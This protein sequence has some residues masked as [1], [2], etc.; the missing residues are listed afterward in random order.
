MNFPGASLDLVVPD[1]PTLD[2]FVSAMFALERGQV[3][4]RWSR[5]DTRGVPSYGIITSAIRYLG[6]PG[7]NSATYVRGLKRDRTSLGD[8]HRLK[9]A[10]IDLLLRRKIP[11]VLDNL[12]APDM[13]TKFGSFSPARVER[14]A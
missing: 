11:R 9:P 2:T 12:S 6:G 7:S 14:G 4:F 3:L 5:Q 13:A 10:V 1:A 8:G